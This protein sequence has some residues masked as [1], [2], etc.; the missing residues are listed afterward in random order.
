MHQDKRVDLHLHS[1]FSDG[2][3]TPGELV[4]FAADRGL[5]AI[6]IADHDCLDG[7]RELSEATAGTNIEFVSGIELSCVN[8]GKDLHVL[9]YGVDVDDAAFQKALSRFRDR[10]EDRGV[11]IIEK[12]RDISVYIDADEVF[13]KAGEGALGRPHIAEA[14]VKAGYAKDFSEAFNKYIGEDCPAYVEKYK[15][16][17]ADAV[18][19]IHASG[20]LALVAHAGYYLE[21]RDAF[22]QLLDHGFD[23]FEIYHP[24]HSN[25]VFRT[26]SEI[27]EERDLVVSGGSDFHGFAE[28]DCVGEP[29]VPYEIFEN[30][31]SRLKTSTY[32]RD[33]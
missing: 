23:G 29:K 15:M 32:R 28:R 1:T 13:A 5:G 14:L 19:Y 8:N 26:L 11:K 24:T 25:G 2:L 4:K 20:G 12:L 18:D 33:T 17:P 21:D 31:T 6:S 27:A 9:G 10:R 3:Y 30:I 7:F 22:Y 16:G